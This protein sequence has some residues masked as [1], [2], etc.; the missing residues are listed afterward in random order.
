VGRLDINS[1]G[2]LLLT[3]D[4]EL[5]HRLMHPSQHLER[6]YA[7]R[8]LGKLTQDMIHRLTR[9][10]KLQDG[11]AHFARIV[12]KPSKGANHWYHVTVMEGRNRI[13][14]RL[15]ESQGVQVSRLIRIRFGK[16]KLPKTLRMGHYQILN[17]KDFT[18]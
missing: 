11:M 16:I 1:S 14:R 7:V 3:N 5:A 10:V 18:V 13:V 6:E 2:L 12:A 15:L 9:G 17:A 8:I 4:G